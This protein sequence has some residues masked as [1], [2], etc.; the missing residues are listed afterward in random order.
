MK[1]SI[2]RFPKAHII[3]PTVQ[4][5]CGL[6][7]QPGARRLQA[8]VVCEKLPQTAPGINHRAQELISRVGGIKCTWEN[9]A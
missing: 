3:C 4:A 7:K 2:L 6:L 1:N 5:V 8:R 9:F